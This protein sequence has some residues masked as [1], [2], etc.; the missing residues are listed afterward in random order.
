MGGAELDMAFIQALQSRSTAGVRA[1]AGSASNNSNNKNN[2]TRRLTFGGFMRVVQSFGDKLNKSSAEISAYMITMLRNGPKSSGTIAAPMRFHDDTSCF[3]GVSRHGGV[4]VVDSHN[5]GIDT[6]LDRDVRNN[7]INHDKRQAT[8]RNSIQQMHTFSV[9][10]Q[11]QQRQQQQPQQQQQHQPQ[12]QHQQEQ[13]QL[14][15]L[16]QHAFQGFATSIESTHTTNISSNTHTA[17]NGAHNNTTSEKTEATGPMDTGA[18][19]ADNQSAREL[20]EFLARANNILASLGKGCLEESL[21]DE[22]VRKET[23]RF[24][25]GAQQSVGRYLCILSLVV[26]L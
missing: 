6:R 1:G 15:G 7:K 3:T 22:R 13:E 26:T 24:L 17:Y 18:R 2:K 8:R 10:Q 20:Q 5:A 11:Q 23:N 4:S 19:P 12:Q 14:L 9:E 25:S 21:K 16:Q